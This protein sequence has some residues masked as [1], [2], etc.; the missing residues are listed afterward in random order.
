M[1]RA[2]NTISLVI[3]TKNEEKNI[4]DCIASAKEIVDEIIVVDMASTDKTVELAEKSGAQVFKVPDYGYVEPARNFALSK[5]TKGWTLVLDGDE[6]LTKSLRAKILKLVK[7]AEYDGFKIPFKNIFFG[8]WIRHSM[9]WPDYHI[10]LFK[11][12]FLDWPKGVHHDVSFKGTLSELEAVEE[13]AIVHNNIADIRE[14]IE[15]VDHYSGV[16]KVFAG[17]KNPT[18]GDLVEY[19]DHEFKWRFLEHKG[20]LDGIHGF[21]LGKFMNMY[22]FLEFAKYW[23]KQKYKKMFTPEQ[24]KEAVER[25]YS[26]DSEKDKQIRE[27]RESLEKIQ[28]AK[29]YK[30]WQSY[31][32]LRD[33]LLGRNK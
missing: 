1:A 30:I 15:M 2:N 32:S 7:A 29:F 10:R 28:S 26:L 14:M 13:N 18:A 20:Y 23:E 12:G 33:R 19:L 25:G 8:T 9:W 27:L 3:N 22:R 11:T 6:R 16:E 5:P 21:V 24:L 17:K 31:C 4:K